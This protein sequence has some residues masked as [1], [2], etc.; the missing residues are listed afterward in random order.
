MLLCCLTANCGA[1]RARGA[2]RRVHRM[3]HKVQHAQVGDMVVV[4]LVSLALQT[5]T[6]FFL[7]LN[8]WRVRVPSAVRVCFGRSCPEQITLYIPSVRL[9]PSKC[10]QSCCGTPR[11]VGCI[12]ASSSPVSHESTVLAVVRLSM[13]CVTASGWLR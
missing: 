4:L 13:P 8:S 3:P 7:A 9:Q 11:L 6:S 5:A 10:H 12:A 2:S 1:L